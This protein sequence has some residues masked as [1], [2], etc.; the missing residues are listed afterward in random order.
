M[1][2]EL[3]AHLR[4]PEDLFRVQTNM[5]GLY[6]IQ[7]A[8]SFY[9]RT[10]A[11]DIAQEPGTVGGTASSPL[12][13]AQGP[14]VGPARENRM[15]P[16]YLL[17][18]LPNTDKED[19]L[20]MQ[21]FVPFSRDDSRK[22]LTAFMVAKSDPSE[23]GKMEAYVM[24]RDRQIE[25]PAQVNSRINQD[26]SVSQEITLLGQRGSKVTFGNMLL[27]PI[28]QSLLW[29][30]PLY[31]EAEGTTP[32][33]QLKKVIVVSGDR[34]VMKDS[35][36]EAL[37]SLFGTSPPTLEQQGAA[38]S[39]P[40]PTAPTTGTPTTPTA[41]GQPTLAQLLGE[42]D[43]HFTAAEDALRRGD[44]TGYQRETNLAR[45]AIKRAQDLASPSASPPTTR[46]PA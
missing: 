46:V 4:Y 7:D 43:A 9:N 29:I 23:Y 11:W 33:P 6:H 40:T 10:D 22:D 27:V 13:N 45:D 32:L 18:K 16:Y 26:P 15:D 36:R 44:L 21:P 39:P 5:Y 28:E 12:Q 41:P 30:R 24:P 37:V 25:G 38:V 34:L 20:L 35:L 2:Q 17:M 42:A 31:V 19:F 1:D 14:T 8:A 3:L